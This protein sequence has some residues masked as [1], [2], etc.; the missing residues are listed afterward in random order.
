MF[1]TEEFIDASF[2]G[3]N[4]HSPKLYDKDTF[5]LKLVTK[6]PFLGGRS[7]VTKT[8]SNPKPNLQPQL[9]VPSILKI[10]KW[11]SIAY[12]GYVKNRTIRETSLSSSN[13]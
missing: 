3:S 12:F 11:P 9:K 7:F 5:K 8:N 1:E 4:I 10:K 6:D 13:Q 2:V